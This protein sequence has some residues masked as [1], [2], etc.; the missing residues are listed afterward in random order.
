MSDKSSDSAIKNASEVKGEALP[1]NSVIHCFAC[2]AKTDL[3]GLTPGDKINCKDCS[4]EITV[5]ELSVINKLASFESFSEIP[6]EEVVKE[7][8]QSEEVTPGLVH[9]IFCQGCNG[10]IDVSDQPV[11]TKFAC[12]ACSMVLKVPPRD[13]AVGVDADKTTKK[14][15]TGAIEKLKINCHTCGAKLD[16]TGEEA[17]R[18]VNCPACNAEFHIPKRYGHFLLEEKLGEN[19]NFAVYRALDLTLSREVCLKVTSKDLNKNKELVEKF[20]SEAGKAALVSD[21]NVVPIYSSGEHE[22]DSYLVMQFM[23]ALSLKPYLEKAKGIL[24][25]SSVIRV[26]KEATKGLAAAHDNGIL[27]RNV[28]LTNILT[29]RE[30]NIKVSDFSFDYSL[31]EFLGKK[32]DDLIKFFDPQYISYEMVKGEEATL[33]GDIFSLGAVFYH[34]ITGVPP[35]PG[36]DP[37]SVIKDRLERVPVAANKVRSEVPDYVSDYI[38]KMMSQDPSNRPSS[39]KDIIKALDEFSS[40]KV[41]S[42]NKAS[43]APVIITDEP[44]PS[45]S[46][47]QVSIP[48]SQSSEELDESIEALKK[49]PPMVYAIIAAVIVVCVVILNLPK[50]PEEVGP[51]YA[52]KKTENVIQANSP[53]DSDEAPQVDE[54]PSNTEEPQQAETPAVTEPEEVASPSGGF[55]VSVAERPKPEA[56][57]FKNA[58]DAVLAYLD[59]HTGSAHEQEMQRLK[60][61]RAI[62]PYILSIAQAL[63]YKG[64]IKVSGRNEIPGSIVQASEDQLSIKPDA[65]DQTL[66]LSW[67]Q[68]D[69][70]QFTLMLDYY[71]QLRS[72]QL[73]S[74]PAADK[75]VVREHLAADY[76][77]LALLCDW[78]DMPEDALKYSELAIQNEPSL[79]AKVKAFV[80]SIGK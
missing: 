71:A 61:L 28:A 42:A 60:T 69:I 70:T 35:F 76:F 30:G 4:V 54:T 11:G 63:P 75:P 77:R 59:L 57:G 25:V 22:G 21:A 73:S 14:D 27:H 74:L 34:L 15:K 52:T 44:S 24:P 47:E 33:A 48:S 32:E 45:S 20:L 43:S 9:K 39:Y 56:L 16:V 26:V 68:F 50:E 55:P 31:Y 49:V 13:E 53:A 8:K 65:A 78:Y 79:E 7:V 36:D 29:D 46:A 5:P 23:N 41:S 51:K 10:K 67:E 38:T 19:A 18:K 64:A 80:P 37:K 12:P 2:G 62:K 1:E 40:G 58:S 3:S 66:A 6:Q 72:E 17:F